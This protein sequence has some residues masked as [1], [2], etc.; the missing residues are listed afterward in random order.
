M[1]IVSLS[2]EG[3]FKLR[4]QRY[5]KVKDRLIVLMVVCI[6]SNI[7]LA[8]FSIDYL[9]KM[10]HNTELMYE[11]RLL[12]INAVSEFE[13]AV[14]AGE[15]GQA[16]E[17]QK[18]LTDYKFDLQMDYYIKELNQL[19][20]NP[21]E[22]DILALTY[23]MKQY[24]TERADIQ[25]KAYKADISFGYK[26]L[27]GLSIVI[28]A[29]VIYFSVGASRSVNIPTRQLKRLLKL[30]QQ[31][32]F[33]KTA[34]YDA[35]DELGE[36]MVSYNQMTTEVKELLKLVQ[37]SAISVDEANVQLQLA[38]E[39]TTKASI[40]ISNDANDLTKTTLKSTEQLNQ[41]T[42]AVQEVAS[43]VGFIAEKLGFIEKSVHHTVVEANEG[44]Q[45]VS[46]NMN[47]MKEIESDVKQTNDMIQV[48]A[49]HSNEIGKVIQIINSIAGQ[50][51][52]LALNAAIEAARAGEYGK[53]FSVVA[54]EVRKL[55]EQSVQ[56]TKVIEE[57]VKL[58]QNDTNE[59]IRFMNNAID[60]VQIGIE[61]TNQT[62]AKFQQIVSDVN[63]IGPQI[64]EV[65]ETIQVITENTQEVATNSVT[66][67][68]VSQQNAGRIKQVT[69]TT[70]EQLAATREM[71][72]E[73]Q[74]ITKNIQSLTHAIHRFT[75]E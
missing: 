4:F 75:V 40:H 49:S 69:T 61:T 22:D 51:N 42:A 16:S 10:E 3:S 41:N 9:R 30:A 29:L 66:L 67:S 50:T 26:L 17:L 37:K 55:A 19:M 71:H 18:K 65:S 64:G 70:E 56:S 12:A 45:I 34:N 8:T 36:V 74:K 47:Q 11:Q 5:I 28:I 25:L 35:K 46:V 39:K 38:S 21:V 60:S 24:V 43:G 59:S 14:S 53:G 72:N 58:I 32:D 44:V 68:E 62:A 57:I 73:I 20:Q 13:F 15:L 63:E 54:D 1:L 2:V 7:I 6:I 31:G 48:L 52:L 23:E 27:I 33:T